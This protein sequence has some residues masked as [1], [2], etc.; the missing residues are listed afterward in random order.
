MTIKQLIF[1]QSLPQVATEFRKMN[2]IPKERQDEIITSLEFLLEELSQ[3]E[4]IEREDVLFVVER[5]SEEEVYY[6][7]TTYPL[8]EL[9]KWRDSPE[10]LKKTPTKEDIFQFSME[11]CNDFFPKF[12]LPQGYSFMLTP[13]EETMGYQVNQVNVE[14]LGAV[15]YVAVFLDEL[16]FFGFDEENTV[17]EKEEL[18]RRH[19]ELEKTLSLPPEEQGEYLIPAEK[20]WERLGIA[21]ERSEVEKEA[22]HLLWRREAVMDFANKVQ[23][24]QRMLN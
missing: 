9:E 17:A 14:F 12:S 16:T 11:E 8:E 3:M 6:D 15:T 20:M 2:H 4:V 7:V 1:Q 22:D 21:D 24:M 10:R 13:R 23:M 19:K 18:D 5:L